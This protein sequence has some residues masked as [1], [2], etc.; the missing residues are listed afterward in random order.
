MSS[1]KAI[2]LAKKTGARLHV[3]HLSTGKETNLFT[4]KIPLKDKKLTSEVC[5][6]HLWFDAEDY[7]EL[8][9]KIKCNPAIKHDHK[10]N[11][12]QA[13][14]DDKFDIIATDH[15][16]HLPSEKGDDYWNA[17]AGLPLV[18]H[19]LQVMLDFYHQGKISLEKLVEK[20]THA[21]AVCF[22]LEERGY[23]REGYKADLTLVD[24][25]KP[26]TVQASN[27]FA[28]CGWSPFEVS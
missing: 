9:T 15:A 23:L 24:L 5:V 1:S 10:E 17:H 28:K 3:F 4:N 11:L 16:P 7:R 14:L 18:Q 12:F 2:E 20:M 22:N 21:P 26:Y 27:L 6:H 25:D 8:G 19:S 13:L